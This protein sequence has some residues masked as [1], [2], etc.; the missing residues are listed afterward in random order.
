M[1]IGSGSSIKFLSQELIS[2]AKEFSSMNIEVD[3]GSAFIL[4][5]NAASCEDLEI[6]KWLVF[7]SQ[8]VYFRI[9]NCST[10]FF[11]SATDKFQFIHF[12]SAVMAVL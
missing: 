10:M 9:S 11:L 1:L 5:A 8:S 6:K 4:Y 12:T 3:S 2:Q 7:L